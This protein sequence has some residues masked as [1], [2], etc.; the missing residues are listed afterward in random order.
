[1]VRAGDA[2]FID[3]ANY[4]PVAILDDFAT[5]HAT[6]LQ[7]LLAELGSQLRFTHHFETNGD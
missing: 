7:H 1:L 4:Q 6:V 3:Y 2:N 5:K